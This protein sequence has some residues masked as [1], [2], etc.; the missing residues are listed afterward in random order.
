MSATIA[1]RRPPTASREFRSTS[2]LGFQGGDKN[3]YGNVGNNPVNLT[4]P[5]GLEAIGHHWVPVSVVTHP[6]VRSRLSDGALRVGLGAW[7]GPTDPPHHFGTYGG[8][9]HDRYNILV[10]EE[11]ERYFRKHGIKQ[12]TAEQM[13]DFASKVE[14]G[15]NHNGKVHPE[16]K[17]F[18]DAIRKEH[19]AWL[20]AEKGRQALNKSCDAWRD[21]GNTYLKNPRVAQRMLSAT[22]ASLASSA[23]LEGAG[24]IAFAADNRNFRDGIRALA[25]GDPDTAYNAFF[26]QTGEEGFYGD[27]VDKGFPRAALV[28]RDRYLEAAERAQ[29]NIRQVIGE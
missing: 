8:V 24:A 4:D 2:P 9:T 26:G 11:L 1:L 28:F 25:D 20:R 16:L 17:K 5:S 3:L 22:M 7:S 23:L 18:N 27:L 10:R 29:E 6:D 14:A 13:Y 19:A 21:R 15:L 12:M